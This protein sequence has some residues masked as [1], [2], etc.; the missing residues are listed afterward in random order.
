MRILHVGKYY[1]PHRGGME[2]ALRH[3][4]EGL[5]GAGQRVRVLVAGDGPTTRRDDLPGEPGGLIRAGVAFTWNS[6]PVTLALA[7]LLHRELAT[8]APDVVHLH[9]PNPLACW[10]W[11]RAG[12]RAREHHRRLAVWHH[13]DIVRQ[14]L[15][16]RLVRPIVRRCL[17]AADGISVSSA[18]LREGSRELA[19]WRDR[20]AVI[21]FGI[22]PEPFAVGEPAAD[23]PFLFLGR[24]VPYKGLDVLLEALVRVPAAR[25]E[26]VGAGPLAGSLA[27]RIAASSLAG[28]VRLRGEVPDAEL[29]PLLARSRA[30][31]LPSRD[32]SETFGL[33]LLEAMA[34][35]LPLIAS[36]LPTGIRQL[37]RPG[38]TGW[39]VPPGDA[40]A[41]AA[42]LSAC[43][44][45]PAEARR[46]G[47]AGRELVRAHYTRE[48]MAADLLAWYSELLAVPPG[49][50]RTPARAGTHG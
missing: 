27:A 18:Q 31:V 40:G 7:R 3:L 13:S 37:A 24:L 1:P 20:V 36:D 17:A 30:L 42:G 26:I 38:H 19:P 23:A 43:L 25:L 47:R 44:E 45:D 39:L 35:G 8:F 28:R 4:A 50:Y 41:L 49:A 21:P 2:T 6:Q 46:R 12:R 48:R 9:T 29:P 32:H 16:G 15:G 10:A 22:D 11:L 5:A 34:A 33:S 14:R